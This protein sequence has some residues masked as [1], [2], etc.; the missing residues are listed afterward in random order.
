VSF[1]LAA[2]LATISAMT[3]NFVVNNLLTY[4]DVRLRGRAL[5][6]GL[7]L[8]FGICGIGATANIVIATW[9]FR[10]SGLWWAA[11]LAGIAVG[12]V[13][14]YTTSKQLVWKVT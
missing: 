13:W 12:S 5:L 8:F 10:A 14:N 4:R 2:V 1:I 7:L 6:R 9:L 11:G 3:S